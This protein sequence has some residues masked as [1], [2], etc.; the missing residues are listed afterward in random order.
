[1]NTSMTRVERAAW[2]LA[3]VAFGL[4][5]VALWQ[6]AAWQKYVSPVFLPGPDRAWQAMMEGFATGALTQQTFATVERMAYG[7]VLA[8]VLG[9][10]IGALIG[11]SRVVRQYL[12]PTLEFIRPLP[13]SAIIPVAIAFFGLT[14]SMVLGVIAF[15]SI[16]PMLLATIHGFASVEPRLVEVARVL[17]L[18]RLQFIF[19]IALPN[20]MPDIFAAMRLGLTI[21]LILSVVGEI[22]AFQG[23]LGSHILEASRSFRSPELF[24]GVILLGI[25]GL[26]SNLVLAALESRFLRWRHP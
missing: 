25:I 16:W 17:K 26:L 10:A 2:S 21:A 8:S 6:F 22:L 18:T 20:A 9:V 15:G 11:S 7:W 1:M 3:S 23:G 12:G 14:K 19:K 13:A 24:A 5:I 4:M